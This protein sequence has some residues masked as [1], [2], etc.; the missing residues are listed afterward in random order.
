[1]HLILFG[2]PNGSGKTSLWVW[3]KQRYPFS[4]P[5][6]YLCA[7]NLVANP[8]FAPHVVDIT[9]RNKY[10]S[11]Y[12]EDLRRLYLKAKVPFVLETVMSHES[13]LEFMQE[14]VDAGYFVELVYATTAHPSINVNRVALRVKQGGHNVPTDKIYSRYERSMTLLPEAIK[15]ARNSLVFDNTVIRTAVLSVD[16]IGHT[17]LLN[18]EDRIPEVNT[19][20]RDR[21]LF[22]LGKTLTGVSDLTMQDTMA[23][24]ERYQKRKIQ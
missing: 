20:I 18:K 8:E 2:G 22:P 6:K 10:A 11:R 19:Y 23:Y 5:S 17:N 14:A 9:Q 3:L 7:D 13:K 16:A 24:M 1:M 15:I 21:I 12:I 4:Y